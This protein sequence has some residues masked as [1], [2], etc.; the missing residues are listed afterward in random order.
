MVM[1]KF[2]FKLQ[3]LLDITISLEKEQK[4]QLEYINK[5]ISQLQ[6]EKEALIYRV[7]CCNSAFMKE[8][9][10]S[11]KIAAIKNHNNYIKFLNGKIES[12][13]DN[14]EK[15]TQAKQKLQDKLMKTM[16]KRK[17][18]EKLRERKL[19]QYRIELQ[20]EEEKI[21]DEHAYFDINS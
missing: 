1:K 10:N 5:R 16:S 6:S 8:I 9:K 15:E 11:V 21:I 4:N 3:S 20:R 14:I 17:I 12:I 13:S 2:K 7:D 18:L 19:E